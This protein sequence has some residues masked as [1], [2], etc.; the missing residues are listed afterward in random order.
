MHIGEVDADRGLA[1]AKLARA[2]CVLGSLVQLKHFRA[3][4]AV[5]YDLARHRAPP[6]KSGIA[7]STWSAAEP[8]SAAE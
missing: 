3:A 1:D 8:A 5:D 4:K 2:R 6:V 7:S